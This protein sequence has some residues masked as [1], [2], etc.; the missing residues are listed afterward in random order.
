MSDMGL[1]R[2][3]VVL[4]RPQFAGNIGSVA[5]VMRNMGLTDLVL[6][7]PEANSRELEARAL[8]THG[9]DILERARTVAELDDAVADCVHVAATSARTGG[10]FRKQSVVLPE[11]AAL[12]LIE[13]SRAGPVA[14]VFGPERSGLSDAEVTR[15]HQLIHI[16]TSEEFAALNLAQAVAI[17]L[18][19]LRRAWLR[20][21][22]TP[23][24]QPQPIAPLADQERAFEALRVALEE[25]Q[26]LFGA[27]AE[28][29]MHGVRH[30]LGRARPSPMEVR[31]IFGMARQIRWF[32]AQRG[33]L[34]SSEEG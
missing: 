5:R 7:A 9:E 25:I 16:P 12:D 30:L 14:L 3:R 24:S 8:A 32:V 2:C 34:L 26:F 31:L 29:L 11:A 6:V 17:C 18:Y 19:E 10:L 15:C 22:D 33:G 27:K 21:S 28:P 13:T 20:V 23:V 1:S 4:V